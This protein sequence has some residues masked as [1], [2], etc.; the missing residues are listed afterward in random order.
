M[1]YLFKII[2]LILFSTQIFSQSGNTIYISPEGSDDNDGSLDFPFKT[3]TKGVNS[4][5]SGTIILLDGIYKEEVLIN[6]KSNIIIKGDN[7][8]NPVIDGTINL[9]DYNWE[10]IGNNIY[11]TSTDTTIWQLFI[12]NNEMVM[13]RWPNA[14]FSDKSIYSWDTWAEGDEVNSGNGILVFDNSKSF[15][16]ALDYDLDTAHAILNIGSFRTWNRKIQF[17]QS[18]DFFT[19]EKVPSGQYKNKH[20]H[21]FVEGDLDLLDT[22]NEWYH[23]PSSGELWLMTDGTNPN[24]LE[25][26][27]KVSTYSFEVKDSDQITI[28][29][30]S[31]FSSTVKVYSTENFILQD[32]NFA[33]PSTSKRMIGDLS[34]PEATTIGI[35]GSKNKVNNSIIRR[36]LFEYTDGDAL[37]IYG[38]NNRIENNFFQYIDYSVAELPGLMV[39]MFIN[40]DKNTIT[41]NTIENVQASATVTPGERSIFSFNKVT[42]TGALQSD[43]SVFQG[44]RNFVADSEV[45]HNYVY[46]T[47]KLALRYDAPGDDPTAAGQRGKMYNNVAINTS[48]IMVKGDF[49]Y[50]ANNTVIGSNKNGI[51]I[52]DEE[53]SNLNTFTQNN[54][55]DKLSGH[56]SLSNYEDKDRDGSPDYP[57]PGTSSNN[58]NGWDSVRTNYNNES[59]INNT[60]YDLID[61]ITLMPLEGSPL[62]DAGISIESIPQEIVGSAPDIGAYE[63]GAEKWEAGIEGWVPDFYPWSFTIDTDGDGTSDNIDNCPLTANPNQ[64][65][66]DGDGIGDECDIIISNTS[67]EI[68]NIE[69]SISTKFK[70]GK[71]GWTEITYNNSHDEYYYPTSSDYNPAGWFQLEPHN[72]STGDFNNDG[73]EDFVVTMAVFPH[74]IERRGR[75]SSFTIGINQGDGSFKI[76]D[77]LF[78]SGE[79]NKLNR[80]FPY[81]V[82]TSDFNNDGTDDIVAA[83]MGMIKRNSDGTH[84][85]EYEQIPLTLSQENK[86]I[87]GSSNI[88]GQKDTG[89]PLGYSFGHDLSVGD[90]NGDGFSDFFT[91]KVLFINDGTG[92]FTNSTSLINYDFSKISYVMTSTMGDLNNDNIDDIVIMFAENQIVDHS[93]IIILSNGSIISNSNIIKID[94]NIGLYG[95][96]TKFNSLVI[97]DVNDDSKN[98]IIIANT[99]AE[100]Y[101][102]G[103]KIQVLLN[104]ENNNFIDKTNLFINSLEIN[105]ELHGEGTLYVKDADSDG[106]LDIIHSGQ[107]FT[108]GYGMIIY[109]NEDGLFYQNDPKEY[110]WV[111]DWELDLEDQQKMVM[112]KAFPINIDNKNGIDFISWIRR[113]SNGTDWEKRDIIFYSIISYPD[114][115]LDGV[116]DSED[117]CPSTFNPDQEDWDNDG[118]GDLCGDPKPLFSEKISFIENIFPNPTS[119]NLIVTIRPEIEVKDIY[120]V[121]LS[122]KRIKPISIIRSDEGLDINVSNIKQ[123]IYILEIETHKEVNK[124]KILIERNK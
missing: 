42:K 36:N 111:Q 120:F 121:D 96:N 95:S 73:L 93:G 44:T 88:E 38:D 10:H 26:R 40:G 75:I 52:L 12:E 4:L 97:L 16:S 123:G 17:S 124:I 59:N 22:L 25:V 61:S 3:I 13:A 23:N 92:N 76:E 94:K 80:Y 112:N 78:V 19:Y 6:N 113:P 110:V 37:R 30:L 47:P 45:H 27:G 99:Q 58:W 64:S 11:K 104:E 102:V 63:Y 57:I 66:I 41:K 48:G 98:D 101:Y 18:S 72:F 51:I 21:F 103:R 28:E 116:L 15:Y 89:L 43:G 117:N 31:F 49:H 108:N 24:D 106:D 114:L 74:T 7:S 55:V 79:K 115:D 87:D 118:I 109:Y 119:D 67:Y 56:R 29:N 91:G 81:R 84:V 35:N 107:D 83:S 122:G 53:N 70:I 77:D 2:F 65:D 90:V 20:H 69:E 9:S 105:S 54:L 100:P 60:I 62:I 68:N 82:M 8:G 50:I 33:F 1:K 32:C 39:T 34:T 5:N 14:Q 85:T 86:F 46:N 71:F